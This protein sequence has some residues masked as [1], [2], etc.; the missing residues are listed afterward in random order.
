MLLHA[1]STA[2]KACALTDGDG[3]HRILR[4]LQ[5]H[6]TPT[7][8]SSDDYLGRQYGRWESDYQAMHRLGALIVRLSG[9][10]S[11]AGSMASEAVCVYMPELF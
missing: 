9:A 1:L 10:G 4:E 3:Y 2:V 7:H 6:I 8:F 5:L 11:G